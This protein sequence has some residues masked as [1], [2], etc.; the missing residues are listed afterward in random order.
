[1]IEATTTQAVE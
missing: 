1:V